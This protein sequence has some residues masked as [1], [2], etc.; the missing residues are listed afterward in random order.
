MLLKTYSVHSKQNC[1]SFPFFF[2]TNTRPVSIHSQYGRAPVQGAV[3]PASDFSF[4]SLVEIIAHRGHYS[5]VTG[6]CYS[7]QQPGLL[8]ALVRVLDVCEALNPEFKVVGVDSLRNRMHNKVIDSLN[9]A[10]FL[11][12][13]IS[14]PRLEQA[15]SY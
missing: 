7:Y 3:T 2:S 11:M 1:A 13:T 4:R 10:S 12:S 6:P 9:T 14:R 8:S 15:L 5:T